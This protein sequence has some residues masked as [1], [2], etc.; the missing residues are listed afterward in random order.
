[1]IVDIV[2]TIRQ[3]TSVP[4]TRAIGFV[5]LEEKKR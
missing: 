5:Q 4:E 1:M 2:K 3:L